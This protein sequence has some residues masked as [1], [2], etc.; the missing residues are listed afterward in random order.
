MKMLDWK[1]VS[2]RQKILFSLVAVSLLGICGAELVS[3]TGSDQVTIPV[4][5]E[6]PGSSRS[7]NLDRAVQ[8]L[9]HS[10]R[11][12]SLPNNLFEPWWRTM[13]HDPD[14]SSIMRHWDGLMADSDRLWSIGE[15]DFGFAP[16]VDVS[17]TDREIKITAEVPGMEEKNLSVSASDDT[18]TIEGNKAEEKRNAGDRFE[19]IE[20]SY[21][22]FSRVI[23]LPCKVLGDQARASLKNGILTVLVPTAPEQK[24][25][26]KKVV[27]SSK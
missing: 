16:R 25:P 4:K 24:S 6:A 8:N 18:V 14:A 1:S 21:G 12:F 2:R 9:R 27:I 17:R 3:A 23:P 11:S 5:K 22:S 20:R 10:A 19:N 7:E 15:G 26:N 13:M